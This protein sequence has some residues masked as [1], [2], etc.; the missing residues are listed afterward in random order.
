MKLI[1]KFWSRKWSALWNPS[2]SEL[3]GK[4]S[5][6]GQSS[7][8]LTKML[9]RKVSDLRKRPKYKRPRT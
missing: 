4:V 2:A 1:N 8:E 5:L 7:E 3:I 9:G 6:G